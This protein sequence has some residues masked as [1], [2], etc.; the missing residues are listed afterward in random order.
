MSHV[1]L[2]L[3]FFEIHK[4]ALV[5]TYLVVQLKCDVK[6]QNDQHKLK[7][8][9]HLLVRQRNVDSKYNVV[10]LNLL[11]HGFIKVP[12]LVALVGTPR[13]EPF[14]FLSVLDCVHTLGGQV[15]D[16]CGGAGSC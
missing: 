14:C 10:G 8:G 9:A 12:D 15:V 16:C 2:T 1:H 3:F 13:H 7:P 11:G 4:K 5:L 6:L